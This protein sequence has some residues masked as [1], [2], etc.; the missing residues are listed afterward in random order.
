M[1]LQSKIKNYSVEMVD[2]VLVK[3]DDLFTNMKHER[4]FYFVD[5]NVNKLY[6]KKLKHF[7]GKNYYYILDAEESNKEYMHL[8][9][10]YK[11]LIENSFTRN[12]ILVTIGGGILQDISGFI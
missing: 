3:G 2:N 6:G 4:L 5:G 10:Y 9:E 1:K 12:D 11:V 7:I 8:A